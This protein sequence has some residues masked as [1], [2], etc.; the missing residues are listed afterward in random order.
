MAGNRF[1]LVIGNAAYSGDMKLESPVNDARNVART[2]RLLNF[3]CI[4]KCN[5]GAD[6]MRAAF[7]EFANLLETNRAEVGLIYFS[8]HGVGEHGKNYLIPIDFDRC[9]GSIFEKSIEINSEIENIPDACNIR[10]LFLDACRNSINSPEIL[11]GSKGLNDLST[12]KAIFSGDEMIR[13]SGLG[14]M[15]ANRNTF[16]AFATAPGGRAYDGNTGIAPLKKEI[17]SP[18]TDSLIKHLEVVDLP[19]TNLMS[20]V[21]KEVY[22]NTEKMQIPWDQSSLD[23]P[24]YF[25]PGSLILY[26]G[27]IMALIGLFLSFIPYSLVIASGNSSIT[28]ILL[29]TSLPLFSL[30]ILLYGM[31]S[32]YSRMRG[33]FYEQG[34]EQST[35][36]DHI[37]LSLEKGVIGGYLGAVLGSLWIAV[38]Y[39]YAWKDAY[40]N[41]TDLDP[42]ESLGN[43]MTEITIATA[44]TAGLLGTLCILSTRIS[45]TQKT[46]NLLASRT[47]LRTIISSSI[48]GM[49]AG[50]TAAPMLMWYFGRL[51]RPEVTPEYLLPGAI[52]GSSILIFAIINFDYETLSF[53]RVYHSITASFSALAF[54]LGT[55]ICI[56]G[57]LYVFGVVSSVIQMLRD[58]FDD[59]STMLA[60]SIAY[61]L[62]V[63][64]ILGIVIGAAIVLTEKWSMKPVI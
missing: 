31:Q 18:F 4:D 52:F 47:S 16:I 23:D 39:Y 14:E 26:I 17:L 62:P 28:Q 34:F 6:E 50:I 10:V 25:N 61:G 19:L 57:P 49:V 58:N 20:R 27:N 44:L 30:L 43:I 9:D 36:R 42:P 51:S 38:P 33:N 64:G 7:G 45:L 46:I 60:G 35:M 29:A 22:E 54:G 13:L 37:R 32:V 21:R 55:T 12:V 2:L 48:G 24:F 8:G 56:F 59:F 11:K 41:D 53:K 5:L 15:K 40:L 63:G 3:E 1:A